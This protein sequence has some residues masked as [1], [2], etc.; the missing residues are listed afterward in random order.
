MIIDLKTLFPNHN[1]NDFPDSVDRHETRFKKI[2]V[3]GGAGSIGSNVVKQIVQKTDS[4]ICILDNDESR[5]HTIFNSFSARD[6]ERLEFFVSDIRDK[7]GLHQRLDAFNPDLIVHAAALKHVPILE[8]QPRDAFLTNVMG[9]SNL[10]E[11]LKKNKGM[12]FVFVSSDKAALP[13]ST[14][15]KTKLVGEYLT[16]SL[17]QSDLEEENT[18]FVSIVRFGNVFLSRGS[19]IETFI[20]QIEKGEPITITDP[21]MTRYFMDISQAANLILYVIE[22]DIQGISIF[23]MGQPI[24]IEELAK[25]LLTYFGAKNSEIKYIGMKSGE[26]LH[27]DLFS[28][29]E[30]LAINDLGPVLNS[31]EMYK[32][33]DFKDCVLPNTDLEALQLIEE[34]ISSARPISRK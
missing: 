10:I 19:V 16:G 7:K 20:S 23:K 17:I 29:L 14:L 21:N 5:L 31:K 32:V 15:G 2:L 18:R 33:Q 30:N 12:G 11:Y 13:K 26:K 28:N 8:R 22:S 27:E 24:R 4:K 3:T 1:A 34:I 25:R 9:T 6:Q